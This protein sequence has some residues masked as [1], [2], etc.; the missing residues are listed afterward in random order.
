MFPIRIHRP[1]RFVGLP[2]AQ[3]ISSTRGNVLR[4]LGLA[5][6]LLATTGCTWLSY[7]GTDERGS[8]R[9]RIYFVGG[10]GSVGNVVGTIDVPRGLRQAGYRGSIE[11]F[12]WQ[13]VVGGT[14]RDLMDRPRNEG[15]ARRLAKRIQ[16]YL[17]QHPGRRVDIIALSAGTGITAWALESLPPDYRVGTVVFLGSALSR[18]YDLSP[19]LCRIDGH[20]YAFYSDRDPLLKFGLALTGSVDR[21]FAGAAGLY[22]FAPPP[23]ADESARRTYREKLRTRPYRSDYAN[24]G[25]FGLHADSTSPAFVA[26]VVYPLLTEP[27]PAPK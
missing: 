24:H 25:Y 6:P 13:S 9:G 20:L 2:D 17:D 11:V 10:A 3:A 16:D 1:G 7:L 15:E 26:K 19:A 8:D 14:L 12:G 18:T 23:E 4:T 22:G 27:P 5:L 21:E